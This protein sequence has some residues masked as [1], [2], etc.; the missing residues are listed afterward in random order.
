MI[1]NVLLIA[2]GLLFI[3]ATGVF[4]FELNCA[5]LGVED[6]NGFCLLDKPS[7]VRSGKFKPAGAAGYSHPTPNAPF[8]VL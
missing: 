1:L 5:P 7:V 4:L 8:P 6:E 2:G 3:I